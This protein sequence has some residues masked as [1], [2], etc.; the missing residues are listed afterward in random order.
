MSPCRV[1]SHPLQ[2]RWA[3][4]SCW[5]HSGP[6]QERFTHQ[7]ERFSVSKSVELRRSTIP[8]NELCLTSLLGA[9]VPYPPPPPP[10]FVSAA[11]ECQLSLVEDAT[12]T[13]TTLSFS[14]CHQ[15]P[16]L[17]F[18]SD[19]YNPTRFAVKVHAKPV[20]LPHSMNILMMMHYHAEGVQH[21]FF[22]F[23]LSGKSLA[24]LLHELKIK[25]PFKP[26]SV[27]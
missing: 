26:V 12:C 8:L 11:W 27:T 4:A 18:L 6:G 5:A 24:I 3:T 10:L 7:T 23:A 9:I 25:I 21:G 14:P 22:H 2:N 1:F 20:D 16:S 17:Y 13:V 15:W 19:T